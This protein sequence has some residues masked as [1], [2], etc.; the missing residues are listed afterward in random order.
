MRHR[1][2]HFFVSTP[3]G[4]IGIMLKACCSAHRDHLLR[5]E[6][7]G[8]TVLRLGLGS[9]LLSS[10][11]ELSSL[12]LVAASAGGPQQGPGFALQWW[13]CCSGF[14]PGRSLVMFVAG[15]AP[16]WHCRL[17]SGS[18]GNLGSLLPPARSHFV[19]WSK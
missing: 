3:F 6:G 17:E 12:S 7:A 16:G 4:K 15:W 13:P 19:I 10:L 2:Q 18:V 1:C 14:S 9:S 11:Q 8:E 5:A